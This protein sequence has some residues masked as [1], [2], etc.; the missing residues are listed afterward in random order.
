[1]II[2]TMDCNTEQGSFSTAVKRWRKRMRSTYR[3]DK[4]CSG[5]ERG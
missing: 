3:R 5:S 2:Q 1:M 4:R